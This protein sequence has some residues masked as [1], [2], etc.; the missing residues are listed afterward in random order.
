MR[1]LLPLFCGFGTAEK[2]WLTSGFLCVLKEYGFKPFFVN[3]LENPLFN[4]KSVRFLKGKYPL[5]IVHSQ[6]LYHFLQ[7]KIQCRHLIVCNSFAHFCSQETHINEVDYLSLRQLKRMQF[8]FLRDPFKVIQAFQTQAGYE[9]I[10]SK[11]EFSKSKK[12]ASLN[13]QLKAL[14]KPISLE[15]LRKK[16]VEKCTFVL[17]KNDPI[18]PEFRSNQLVK[19]VSAIKP[20]EIH[21]LDESVHLST[22]SNF[23]E[24]LRTSIK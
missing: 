23:Y 17:S 24:I 19:A 12:Y 1:S 22:S 4:P 16:V 21:A 6:G 11:Q 3:T 14:E 7:S 9:I 8:Q 18:V 10:S 15:S 13:W 2:H 20:I 5:I